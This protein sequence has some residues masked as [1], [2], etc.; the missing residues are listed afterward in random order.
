MK[1]W[2]F[3]RTIVEL[4]YVSRYKDTGRAEAFNR[5]IVELK[6][7]RAGG[8]QRTRTLLIVP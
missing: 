8:E 7:Y 4:K 6:Y 5:T 1:K 2:A 3:N